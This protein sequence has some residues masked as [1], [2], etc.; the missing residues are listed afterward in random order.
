MF[1]KVFKTLITF[2]WHQEIIKRQIPWHTLG[3]PPSWRPPQMD[4]PK[5][6]FLNGLTSGASFFDISPNLRE[7]YFDVVWGYHLLRVPP[8]NGTL[9]NQFFER[10]NLR[11]QCFSYQYIFKRQI[12]LRSLGYPPRGTPINQF[13]IASSYD[14]TFFWYQHISKRRMLWH[15]LGVSLLGTPSQWTPPKLIFRL[16]QNKVPVFSRLTDT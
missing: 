9:K 3:V 2:S 10:L 7:K 12:L 16:A 1:L 14:T 5:I 13:L 8:P 4:T 15:H 11:W 6:N